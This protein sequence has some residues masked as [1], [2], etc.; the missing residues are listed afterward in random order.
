MEKER[1][2]SRIY[3]ISLATVLLFATI[4]CGLISNPINQ[5]KGL[6]ATAQ[7]MASAMPSGMPSGMPNIPGLPDV[8]SYLDPTGT[9]VS[10]WNGIPIMSQATAGQEFNANTYSFKAS[11]ITETDVQTFY[12][13][14]LKTLGWSPAFGA[15]GG[16]QGG[17]LLFTKESHFLTIT[18]TTKDSAVVVILLLQ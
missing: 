10:E 11:G 8:G 14:Q 7:A 3:K 17:L 16:A 12:D 4:A 13:D 15:Q 5:A 18:V 6:A 2:M 1:N 9:P